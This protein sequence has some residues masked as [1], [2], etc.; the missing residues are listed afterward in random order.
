MMRFF[1]Y[2]CVFLPLFLLPC[3]GFCVDLEGYSGKSGFHSNAGYQYVSFGQYAYEAD[4]AEQPVL[5]RVLGPGTPEAADVIDEAN[6]P[7]RAWGKE[8]NGDDCTGENTDVYC[9]MSEYILDM[10]LYN[11]YKDTDKGHGLNY[12]DSLM[13]STLNE[14]VLHHMFTPEEQSV[15]VFMPDRGLLGLPTRKGELFREDYGFVSEDFTF[16]EA[17]RAKGT[18]YAKAHGLKRIDGHSWYFTAD[19]RRYGSR[20]IVGDNGHISVSGV[21][22]EGGVRLICYVH[23]DML[24]SAGGTGTLSDPLRLVPLQQ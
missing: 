4:G 11:N 8:P 22:R 12:E 24:D 18:P 6:V 21:D 1:R 7:P 23:A 20:W 13:Y 2:L 9:L 19:W 16:W 5:W 17:R 14:S 3:A 10:I 15:L